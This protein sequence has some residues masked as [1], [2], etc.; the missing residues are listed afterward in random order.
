MNSH[1]FA[2]RLLTLPDM[3][4]DGHLEF[5]VK[6]DGTPVLRVYSDD[7]L[8]AAAPEMLAALEDMLGGWIYIRDAHGDLYGVGWDR[9]ERKAK[10]AIAKAT[11][12]PVPTFP[13]E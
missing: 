11:G 8:S 10:I 2:R 4:M 1:D 13:E 5:T 9:A 6:S 7:K 12:Q 3:D